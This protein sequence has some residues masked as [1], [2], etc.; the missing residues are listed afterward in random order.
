MIN[1]I[2]SF[3]ESVAYSAGEILLEGFRS[4]DL[5]ISYKSK[6]DLVTNIDL[7]SEKY[8]VEKVESKYP[9]HTIIAEEG[10]IKENNGNYIWYI[11]PLDATN[12]YAHGIPYFAVSIGIYSIKDNRMAGGII[13]DP[14]HD[15]MFKAVL[16]KPALL[17]NNRINVS[18]TKSLDISIL[19]TG[20]SK[21]KKNPKKNNLKYF[22]KFLPEVQGIR[23]IGSAAMDLAYTACG[24]LD[25]YWE[26]DLKSWDMAAGSLI[27]EMAG[28]TVSKYD[29]SAFDSNFP[30]ILA[31]NT[32]L[33]KSMKKILS[34][35]KS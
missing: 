26:E 19:A 25:G 13:F 27:V 7:K 20:F 3:A 5:E 33:H 18:D 8:I 10:H 32:H 28:G 4:K 9:K 2:V 12:N 17:N 1:E 16:N 30:E 29:G 35:I 34:K 6:T 11:D 31:T 21:D 14:Y 15:E 22:N 24:R 23:R